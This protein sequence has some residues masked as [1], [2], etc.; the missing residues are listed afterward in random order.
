MPKR[1]LICADVE[2]ASGLDDEAML[3]DEF[4]KVRELITGDVNACV[5][6]IR[7]AVPD[8]LVDLF[9]AHGSGGNVIEEKL[10]EGVTLLGGGWVDTLFPLVES[11]GLGTYDGVF[12]LGQHAAHGTRDG[13]ISHTN[14]GLCGLQ[15]NGRHA[16]EAPQ[17]AWLAGVQGTPTLLVVGDRATEREVNALLPGVATV[18]VKESRGGRQKADCIPLDQAQRKIEEVAAEAVENLTSAV[19]CTLDEPVQMTASFVHPQMAEVAKPFRGVSV[20]GE[21][22]VSFEAETY[23]DGWFHYQAIARVCSP[24]GIYKEGFERFKKIDEV[25]KIAGELI[26][27]VKGLSDSEDSPIPVVRY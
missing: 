8:A 23:V 24:F 1:F 11:P 21:R 20:S 12:L 15:V 4:E 19:P 3:T 18:S 5:R 25:R 16:G 7:S 13:F 14:N 2:G 10:G 27:E 9:D 26:E 22:E 17:L 6:G